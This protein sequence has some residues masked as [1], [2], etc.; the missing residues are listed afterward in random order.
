LKYCEFINFGNFEVH[1][2]GISTTFSVTFASKSF[3]GLERIPSKHGL[4]FRKAGHLVFQYPKDFTISIELL[5]RD[6]VWQPQPSMPVLAAETPANVRP[7]RVIV[8]W[9]DSRQRVLLERT[10]DLHEVTEA[11]SEL[12][13]PRISYRTKITGVAEPLTARLQVTVL[14]DRAHWL[15]SVRGQL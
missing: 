12:R 9:L 7:R 11:W 1:T 8:R 13:P 4:Q 15:G 5:N 2:Q 14:G 3:D 10:A 6:P